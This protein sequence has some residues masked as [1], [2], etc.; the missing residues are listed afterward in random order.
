MATN[1]F[2]E[3]GR[4][5]TITGATGGHSSGD[6]VEVLSGS[7]G[8]VGVCVTDIA[9]GATGSI[10]TEGVYTVA[11]E[12]DTAWNIGDKVYWDGT[13]MTKTASGATPAGRAYEAKGSSATTGKVAL[14]GKF[15]I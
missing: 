15:S 5:Q 2:K 9:E 12:S 14:L 4:I 7:S 3:F 1:R 13:S 8:Y 6:V 11:A 10:D